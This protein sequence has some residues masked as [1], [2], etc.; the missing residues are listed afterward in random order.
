MADLLT[1]LSSFQKMAKNVGTVL[2]KTNTLAE[3][4]TT[5]MTSRSQHLVDFDNL[6]KTVNACAGDVYKMKVQL[7]GVEPD[8]D[9]G[10]DKV[11]SSR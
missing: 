2:T 11:S 5:L 9:S 7:L 1:K 4:V 6:R 10:T 3:T 8:A